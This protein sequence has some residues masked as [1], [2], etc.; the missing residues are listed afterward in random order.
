VQRIRYVVF[1]D[2]EAYDRIPDETTRFQLARLVGKLNATLDE[3]RFILMG[4]GRWGSS[5]PDLGI[6]VTYADIYKTAMLIEIG[7][8]DGGS[9]PEASYGTHFFQDLVE[10]QIHPLALFPGQGKSL[11]NW[12]FFRKSPN[13][14]ADLLPKWA[15]YADYIRV[16]DVATTTRG[17]LLEVIMDG[18]K[19]QALGYL[20]RYSDDES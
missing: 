5:N 10:A 12:R 13:V 4:P 11:V 6:K 14:L 20:R 19:G 17:R 3:K 15:Q 1:V 7:L 16:I 18:E 9:T 2:P 8:T